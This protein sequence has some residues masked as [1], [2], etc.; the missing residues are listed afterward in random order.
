MFTGSLSHW[1][2]CST[3]Q[4]SQF[5]AES[6]WEVH[7][8]LPPQLWQARLLQGQAGENFRISQK[9]ICPNCW[10]RFI[11]SFWLIYSCGTQS[12]LLFQCESSLVGPPARC[13]CVSSW[14]G[15]K[16]PGSQDL[17]GDSE[18]HQEVAHW[19]MNTIITHKHTNMHTDAYT[20]T[21]RHVRVWFLITDRKAQNRK[22]DVAI[23]KGEIPSHFIY[24]MYV[25]RLI[26]SYLVYSFIQPFVIYR[27]FFMFAYF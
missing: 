4:D 2:A 24:L 23:S 16:I 13:W 22:C 5:S 8:F 15:K 9:I 20:S 21:Y 12:L 14:N 26:Y 6:G 7:N 25:S 3:G 17:L 11:L 27:F 18:C 10:K 19:G 1:T